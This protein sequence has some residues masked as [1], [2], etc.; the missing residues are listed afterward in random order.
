MTLLCAPEMDSD[1]KR[2]GRQMAID[3]GDYT[4][5]AAHGAY[6]DLF[7]PRPVGDPWPDAAEKR[8]TALERKVATLE[9]LVHRLLNAGEVAEDDGR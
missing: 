7:H 8:I 9:T 6:S 4:A 3:G 5:Y 1:A 2:K